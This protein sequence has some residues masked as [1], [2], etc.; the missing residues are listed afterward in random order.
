MPYHAAGIDCVAMPYRVA[1]IDEKSV[2]VTVDRYEFINDRIS[3]IFKNSYQTGY[4]MVSQIQ[5]F[6]EQEKTQDRLILRYDVLGTTRC[7]SLK[8]RVS[9]Q[10][11]MSDNVTLGRRQSN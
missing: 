6:M 4:S 9:G 10:Y 1:G 11:R 3:T 5:K 7:N 8:I 2:T